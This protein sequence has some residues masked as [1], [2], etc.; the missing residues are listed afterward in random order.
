MSEQHM[1]TP[2]LVTQRLH[3]RPITR[4]DIDFIYKLFKRPETNKYSEYNDLTSITEAVKMYEDYLKP[5]KPRHFRVI[6]ELKET[7]TP[8][9]TIGLYQY[10]EPHKRAE[11]GYDLLRKYWGKGLTSEAVKEIVCY[12]FTELGL[13]R[14]AATVD[15]D[16]V[17]SIGVLVKSGFKC[18]GRLRRRFKYR[19]AWHDE[20]VYGLLKDESC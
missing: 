2:T 18:E 12:G 16:N 6:I 7:R 4:E 13:V 8:I 15:P 20:L 11:V 17:A 3:L 14:V 19:G 10:S 9:G 1:H 5:G